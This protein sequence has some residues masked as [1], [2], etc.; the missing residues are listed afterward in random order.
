MKFENVDA[1]AA[2]LVRDRE[3]TISLLGR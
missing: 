3:L 1:L 2:Q